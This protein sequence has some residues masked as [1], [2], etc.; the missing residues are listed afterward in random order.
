MTPIA[1]LSVVALDCPDPTA[2]ARFY[3]DLTGWP[4]DPGEQE[5]DWVQLRP[6]AGDGATAI[7]FQRVPGH[8]PPT[9]PGD[10]RAQQL[11]LDFEVPDLDEGERRVLEIG[12]RKAEVQPGKTW[13]VYLDPA[14]HP[15]CLV[16]GA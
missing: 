8:R 9:W 6:G 2:L 7:A 13:R 16:L 5:D 1:R 4:V 15:F 14:G 10:E 12:A 11:H 3:T